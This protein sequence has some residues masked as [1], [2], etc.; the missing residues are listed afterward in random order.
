M[1][2]TLP[3]IIEFG[4]I[5]EYLTIFEF[6]FG[7][8]RKPAILETLEGSSSAPRHNTV[9]RLSK[10]GRGIKGQN[11]LPPRGGIAEAEVEEDAS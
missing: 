8:S 1:I 3:K 2:F 5:I 4:S 10:F 7:F 6:E 11:L 9:E